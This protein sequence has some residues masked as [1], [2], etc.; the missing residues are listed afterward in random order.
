MKNF[1]RNLAVLLGAALFLHVGSV[2]AQEW[3]PS[4]NVEFVV[5]SGPGG[6]A[7][8]YARAMGQVFEKLGLLNGHAWVASNRPS[9]TG[10]AALQVMQQKQGNPHVLT[11]LHTGIT[12]S[13]LTGELKPKPSD[14]TPVATFLRETMAVTVRADSPLSTGRGLVAALKRDPSSVRIG[15]LGHHVLLSLVSPLKAAGVDI[16]K[17][18]LVPYRSTAE[19][20]TSL[21]GGHV[22]AVPGSTPN[23]VA[24]IGSGRLRALAISAPER[25]GGVF[26]AAPTWR[27]QGVNANFSSVLGVMLP[28]EAP[29]EAVRFWEQAFQSL[30]SN[31]DWLAML[32]RSGARPFFQNR[33]QTVR[34]FAE[35]REE[36]APLIKELGLGAK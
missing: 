33:A 34:Y 2:K 28:R 24:M 15:Y 30:S 29:P 9:G 12:I 17:L 32:E 6:A 1:T 31:P 27:E 3:T 22:D 25:L 8:T 18:T 35:E 20:L 14:F 26:A 16:S 19:A 36:L 10:I 4:S 11:L 5:P 7:D 13:N 21:L 23:L